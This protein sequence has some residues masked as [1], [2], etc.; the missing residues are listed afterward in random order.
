MQ[1]YIEWFQLTGVGATTL[2]KQMLIAEGCTPIS[3][4]VKSCCLHY[5]STSMV[6]KV[7]PKDDV[8]GLMKRPFCELSRMPSLGGGEPH[9]AILNKFILQYNSSQI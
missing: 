3:H 6:P 4:G 5:T 7:Q 2:Q 9:Q 8:L 1:K